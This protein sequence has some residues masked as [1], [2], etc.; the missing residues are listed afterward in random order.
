MGGQLGTVCAL[1]AGIALRRS[2]TS[3]ADWSFTQNF[4]VVAAALMVNLN[5]ETR[6]YAAREILVWEAT[7]GLRKLC[8]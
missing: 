7:V 1:S 8:W 2:T 5:I 4:L 6:P 3:T